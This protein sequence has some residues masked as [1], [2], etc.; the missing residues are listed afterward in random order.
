LRILTTDP[1]EKGDLFGRLVRDVFLTL[2]YET[3]RLNISKTGRE[4]DLKASHRVEQRLAIA[5]CKAHRDPIGGSDLNK[6]A[7]VLEVE[8]H[9]AGSTVQGYFL[10]LSGFR[11]S[12]R[13][14]EHEVSPP[15]FVLLDSDSVKSQ[16]I[17]G[18][19]IASPEEACGV[20]GKLARDL[21]LK[22]PPTL[23]GHALGWIWR[24][25]F[26]GET[27]HKVT[28]FAL[29]HADGRPL[30]RDL[31]QEVVSVDRELGGEL[32]TLAYLEPGIE[33]NLG[34]ENEAYTKYREHI[35][36]DLGEITL[37][38]LPADE[39]MGARRIS[40]EDLYV[41]LRLEPFD[42]SNQDL[43]E[44]TELPVD[45]A[46]EAVDG[47]S[48]DTDDDETL[49][50]GSILESGSRLVILA[51]PGAGK[52]TLVKR[53]SVAYLG[54]DFRNQIADELPKLDVLP[55][56]IRCRSLG[57]RSRWTIREIIE[58]VPRQGEF[59]EHADG[60]KVLVDEAL[61]SGQVLL[62]V[63][64]LDEI[65]SESDR[66][67]FLRQLRTFLATYPQVS[68]VLT[69]R[70]AGFRDVGGALTV[71][72]STYRIADLRDE[73]IEQLV[74]R[75]HQTVVG[76]ST[77][78][79]E[80]AERLA[81]TIIGTDRV[82]KLARNPLLL[83]TLLLVKR[84]VGD[85]PR[86]RSILYEKAIEVLLMTWNVE[87]HDP[88]DRD[89]AI[90]QLAYVAHALT[91]DGRQSVSSKGL[92]NLLAAAREQMPEILG[93]AN[94]SVAAFIRQIESRSS[95]LIMTGHVE[96]HGR[97]LPLYEFRHLT[98]QEYLTALS[99]VEGYYR[100][101]VESDRLVDV[102]GPHVNDSRW[103]EVLSL[104]AVL[105][106]RHAK[107]LALMLIGQCADDQSSGAKK[108]GQPARLL[109]RALA[110]EVQLPPDVVSDVSSVVGRV[111]RFDDDDLVDEILDGRYGDVFAE[112]VSRAFVNR[113]DPRQCAYGG[114][115]SDV[116]RIT[117]A[118]LNLGNKALVDWIGR[119]LSGTDSDRVAEAGMCVMHMAFIAGHR[120]GD[121]AS[122]DEA[123]LFEAWA[124]S[125]VAW[126]ERGERA[127]T[128]ASAWALAWLGEGGW[129]PSEIRADGLRKLLAVWRSDE[130]DELRKLAA[131]AFATMPEIVGDAAPVGDADEATLGFIEA[132]L[133]AEEGG[134]KRVD[135]GP[136]AVVLA[137]YAGVEWPAGRLEAEA[138]RFSDSWGSLLKR[139]A[140]G[141]TA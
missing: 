104:A 81:R 46:H 52:S 14:Q 64:G 23:L 101:H 91:A 97:L 73:D 69:S 105:A 127:V 68:L 134:P 11:Q 22:A 50:V 121:G 113:E 118:P 29:V 58:D 93:F 66:A 45:E 49:S 36:S 17:N 137:Y 87:A 85:L 55:L 10:S 111:R 75:W 51:D 34:Q 24:C 40:L 94:T 3:P 92:E 9:R 117:H 25:D 61:R 39:E 112:T 98:F 128:Y 43:P 35:L 70:E 20:A 38:G 138:R 132:E 115:Y 4:I 109:G 126:L 8:A 27:A 124:R 48:S 139:L 103:F 106:G 120:F 28:H 89:E 53:L 21:R 33:T 125:M 32:H 6:F 129:V 83:T 72:A 84:W 31:A 16:L 2:G 56:F 119:S 133:D 13:E 80:E 30:A 57:S 123:K 90:P 116:C 44:Q 59:S 122:E 19:V 71:L 136:A 99:L 41:P 88:I 108:D 54:D 131:W 135:R 100:G 1:N 79:T 140:Q 74:L 102:I 7:G 42:D 96:E 130:P 65:S 37:E 107:E 63:D 18:K 114:A 77:T 5:E 141:S 15:R 67:S 60:F 26:E 78:V 47:L 62:M 82:R 86:K 12:A 76:N 110:D 95:L